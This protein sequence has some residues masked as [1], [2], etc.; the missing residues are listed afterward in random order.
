MDTLEW[1]FDPAH[2]DTPFVDIDA[3]DLTVEE[4]R[5][6]ETGCNE[7]ILGSV[8]IRQVQLVL[9][10][11]LPNGVAEVIDEMQVSRYHRGPVSSLFTQLLM[12]LV[13]A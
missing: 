13:C 11:P 5:G 1:G 9:E 2:N 8:N 12:C 4:I 10:H 6:V 3:V 7:Y